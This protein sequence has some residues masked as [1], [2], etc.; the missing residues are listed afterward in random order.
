MLFEKLALAMLVFRYR[1]VRVEYKE[2]GKCVPSESIKRQD[3]SRPKFEANIFQTR[4]LSSSTYMILKYF[5]VC[6][7]NSVDSKSSMADF[8]YL[9]LLFQNL[10]LM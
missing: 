4:K 2:I 3:R 7:L 8:A 6:L 10:T 1:L 9:V 5:P